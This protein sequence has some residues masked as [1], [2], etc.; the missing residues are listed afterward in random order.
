M[1]DYEKLKEIVVDFIAQSQKS[2]ELESVCQK[3]GIECDKTLDPNNS[4]RIYLRSGFSKKSFEQVK[5]IA[6]QIVSEGCENTFVRKVEPYMN[7]DFFLIP[8]STRRILLQWLSGQSSLEGEQSILQI[9]SPAWDIDNLT[10]IGWDGAQ[11]NAKE[12]ITQHM[13]RN[14]DITYAELFEN[15]L[16]IMYCTDRQLVK[17][18]E[19][20]VNSPVRSDD[21]EF[22]VKEIN[23]ILRTCGY[24]LITQKSIAGIPFYTLE[25]MSSG[26]SGKICN[27]I[28]GAIGGK[29]DIVIDDALTNTLK[30]LPNGVDCLIYTL[31][32]SSN[33]LTWDELVTWWNSG[34]DKYD[35]SIQQALVSRLVASLDFEPEK[36]FL[37]TYYNYLYKQKNYSLPA[38]IPQVYCHY[39]PQ[40]AR[41]RNGRVYVLQRMDFLLLFPGNVRVIVE[42][43]GKQ[44]YTGAN[45]KSSPQKYAEMVKEDRKLKL[46]GY[47]IYR[48]GG[49]E[50][51][52]SKIAVETI[53]QFIES[54]YQ[55]YG[56]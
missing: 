37:R 4:K 15:L 35:L 29:P 17:L 18:L 47:D 40:T 48:F 8:M 52:D 14:H 43:D 26:I 13:I 33:G 20:L 9:I 46:Y 22:Y 12:Y 10:I 32:I 23:D 31:P 39:D 2:Y 51:S 44:H 41:M 5:D 3:Y 36:L 30:I 49:A 1:T 11:H 34:N 24:Q 6:R 19:T 28:F 16:D 53:N 27:V 50:F 56:I 7:D 42:I 25:K 21:Q 45:D 55:K 54:L 38:L